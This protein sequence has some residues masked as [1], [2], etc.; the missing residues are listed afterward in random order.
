MLGTL[1]HWWSLRRYE[2]RSLLVQYVRSQYGP[3]IEPPYLAAESFYERII[4]ESRSYLSPGPALDVGCATGRLVFEWERVSSRA[5][6]IDTSR[7]FI[8]YCL[9]VRQGRADIT[10]RPKP[11]SNAEFVHGDIMTH[12][13]P[14]RF[15]FISCINL[16]DRVPDPAR[17]ENRLHTLLQTN[18]VLVVVDPYDW[19]LSPAPASVRVADMKELFPPS[20]W[21]VEKEVR[22]IPYVVPM[23]QEMR[24]LCHLLV[25]RK[26]G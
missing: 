5:L 3:F 14:E 11:S 9:L 24:Y 16:I 26:L 12:A 15:G 8:R 17:L 4:A 7:R 21:R 18:G 22:E 2:S 13:F 1:R 23:P 25:L 20:R 19:G 6:G 10:Y